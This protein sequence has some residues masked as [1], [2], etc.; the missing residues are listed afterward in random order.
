MRKFQDAKIENLPEAIRAE[1]KKNL[2]TERKEQEDPIFTKGFL[3]SGPTGVGKTY[4]LHA[5]QNHFRYT[6][7]FENWVTLLLEYK[8]RMENGYQGEAIASLFSKQVLVIDDIGAEKITEWA[9]ERLYIIINKA[10]ERGHIVIIATNLAPDELREKY[11]DR[12]FSRLNE[13]CTLLELDGEDRR[14]KKV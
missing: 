10:Y 6:M 14:M 1:I 8:D 3:I 13:M 12:I 7:Q 9:I 11:G 2:N 4:I 5:L